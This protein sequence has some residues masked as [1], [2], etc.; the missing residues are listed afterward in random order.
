MI[1]EST[2]NNTAPMVP[3]LL[4][5]DLDPVAVVPDVVLELVVPLPEAVRLPLALPVLLAVELTPEE[6][7]LVALVPAVEGTVILTP[8]ALQNPTAN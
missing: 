7:P 6:A 3:T 5:S 1:I 8:A 2:P 4:E